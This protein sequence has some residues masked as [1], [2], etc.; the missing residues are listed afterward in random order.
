MECE[1]FDAA[2]TVDMLQYTGVVF[3]MTAKVDAAIS[4]CQTASR[5]CQNYGYVF[6]LP[7]ICKFGFY[8]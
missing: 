6:T 8:F 7:C 5:N 2:A 1:S 4:C 3:G